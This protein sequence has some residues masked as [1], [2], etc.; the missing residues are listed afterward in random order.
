MWQ[1]GCKVAE[2]GKLRIGRRGVDKWKR[3]FYAFADDVY[4]FSNVNI[5]LKCTSVN[6]TAQLMEQTHARCSQGL[7]FGALA[8]LLYPSDS[9]GVGSAGLGKWEITACYIEAKE[10]HHVLAEQI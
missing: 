7:L 10:L 3:T 8:A 6:A 9:T 5:P 1:C 2:S 4:M